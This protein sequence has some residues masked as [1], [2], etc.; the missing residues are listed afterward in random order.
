MLRGIID[1]CRLVFANYKKLII[2]SILFLCLQIIAFLIFS[3]FF[4]G[5]PLFLGFVFLIAQ[6]KQILSC[7]SQE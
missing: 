3:S 6:A 5:G 7:D 2:P 4:M 1:A